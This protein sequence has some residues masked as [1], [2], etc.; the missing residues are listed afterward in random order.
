[1]GLNLFNSFSIS[2]YFPFNYLLQNVIDPEMPG[3]VIEETFNEQPFFKKWTNIGMPKDANFTYA[4]KPES[5]NN[6]KCLYVKNQITN[7]WVYNHKKYIKVKSGDRFYLEGRIKLL[8]EKLYS[9]IS[10][11]TFGQERQVVKWNHYKKISKNTGDWFKIRKEF[12]ITD[13]KVKYIQ[14]RLVGYGIG[15]YWLDDITVGKL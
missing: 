10:V 6:S 14:L 15:Q 4:F 12:T 13:D 2:N 9:F 8:G 3:I 7:Y 11:T 1:M 5:Y